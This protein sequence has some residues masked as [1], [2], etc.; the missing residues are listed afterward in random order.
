MDTQKNSRFPKKALIFAAVY[1]ALFLALVWIINLQAVNAWIKS[2][3]DL[4]S[5]VL[6]G[7]VLAYLCNPIFR[8]FEQKILAR[9]RPQALRRALSLTLTYVVFFLIVALIVMLIVPQLVD[10]IISFATNYNSY[11]SSA[12]ETTNRVFA[13]INAFVEHLT[14]NREFLQYLDEAEIRE[15]AANLF[16]DLEKITADLLNF[17]SEVD[18][19]PI[20]TFFSDALSV[21]TNTI[22][23][24]FVSIYLLST[25]ERRAAQIMKLRC[26]FLSDRANERLTKIIRTTDVSFGRFFE[27]KLL[28]AFIFGALSYV[29]LSIFAVPYSLLIA[30]VLGL[31]N[32]IPIIG[33]LIGAIPSALILLLSAPEKLLPFL[34]IVIVIQQLDVNVICPRILGNNTGVSSLCVMIALTTMGSLWGFFGMIVGVPLFA[35]ILQLGEEIITKKLQKQGLPSGLANYYDNDAVVDPIKNAHITT[36]KSAQRFEKEALRIRKMNE[37]GE[38]LNRREQFTLL[39]YH[40]ALKYRLLSEMTDETHARYSAE[41][42]AKDAEQ[43][44]DEYFRL[45]NTSAQVEEPTQEPNENDGK[46]LV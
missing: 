40:S 8:L 42:A 15:D 13:D 37:N 9:V 21:V 10:S 4:L 6:I 44:A 34:I 36:D 31:C 14:G 11:I 23:G 25:K 20:Q 29:A 30:T 19:S 5:P 32:I 41:Q 46:E 27:G 28:D 33:P 45:R 43:E 1:L 35:T 16:S 26:A 2:V 24:I 17:L 18:I 22:F 12:I 39:L 7:L 38:K 3:I